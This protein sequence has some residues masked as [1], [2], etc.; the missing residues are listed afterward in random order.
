M[1]VRLGKQAFYRQVVKGLADAYREP[2][3][4]WPT[5]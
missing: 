2:P 4:S 5:T 3:A 1:T